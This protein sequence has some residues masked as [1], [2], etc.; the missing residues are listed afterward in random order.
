MPS[1][2]LFANTC[3][4]LVET[5]REVSPSGFELIIAAPDSAEYVAAVPDAE[6]RLGIVQGM[7]DAFCR[8]AQKLRL[9]QLFGAGFDHINL[10]AARRRRPS[11]C[12]RST[13][14]C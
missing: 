6:Y 4:E 12:W 7:D 9:A 1:K 5:A 10:D 13:T 14:S 8:I 11:Q 2:I 3:A